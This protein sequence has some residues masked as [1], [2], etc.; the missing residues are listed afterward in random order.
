M[1]L[2]T[3]FRRSLT[4][5]LA[6]AGVVAS[7]VTSVQA[8]DANV[9]VPN[10]GEVQEAVNRLQNECGK[11]E[12]ATATCQQ[13]LA[14]G[15]YILENN[16]PNRYAIFMQQ[17]ELFLG[18]VVDAPIVKAAMLAHQIPPFDRLWRVH[19]LSR[20]IAK[21]L[22]PEENRCAIVLSMTLG[23]S[24]IPEKGDESLNNIE[25][26]L[27]H[28]II[29]QLKKWGKELWKGQDLEQYVPFLKEIKDTDLAERFYIKSEQLANRLRDEWSPPSYAH[30]EKKVKELLLNKLGVVFFKGGFGKPL[31]LNHIDLWNGQQW[32]TYDP[33][34]G[35]TDFKQASTRADLVWFWEIPKPTPNPPTNLRLF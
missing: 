28:Q 16:L 8:Q 9:V 2:L 11:V 23:L 24:P 3:I 19:H 27:S 13:L 33:Q 4:P 31:N 15:K 29:G 21:G 30:G 12:K 32:A 18:F 25:T 7:Q 34:G 20:N 26:G 17:V 35:G 6:I 14:E 22:A 10:S 5:L 1:Y